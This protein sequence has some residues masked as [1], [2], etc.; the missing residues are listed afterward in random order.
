MYSHLKYY[1][2]KACTYYIASIISRSIYIIYTYININIY[3]YVYILYRKYEYI[4]VYYIYTAYC[5]CGA[6]PIWCYLRSTGN[7][8]CTCGIGTPRCNCGP[9]CILACH[10]WQ[11]LKRNC[12]FC[13]HCLDHSWCITQR[14]LALNLAHVKVR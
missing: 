9:L 12:C 11:R 1:Y 2:H 10:R 6:V 7:H 3:I 14:I 13:C 5:S 4:C 8:R